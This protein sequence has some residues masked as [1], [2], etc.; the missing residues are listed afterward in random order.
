MTMFIILQK[1]S[2]VKKNRTSNFDKKRQD[3][4]EKLEK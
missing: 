1:N 4:I 2:N 3:K